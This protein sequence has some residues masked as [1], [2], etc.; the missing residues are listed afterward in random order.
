MELRVLI[1]G[2]WPSDWLEYLR[3]LLDDGITLSTDSGSGDYHVLVSGRPDESLI[4]ASPLLSHLII[5]WAGLPAGTR[6]LM[7][8]HSRISVHNIHHNSG[9][10][11]EL[12]L[13]LILA[14]SRL[15]VPADRALRKGD[16]SWR[17]RQEDCVLI[18]GSRM[19]VL[20]Y[21]SIG[22]KVAAA[23]LALGA[24]VTGIR[25]SGPSAGGEVPVVPRE[26]L[27]SLLPETDILLLSLPLTGET[28]DI[29]DS[30]RLGLMHERSVLVNI[31][32]GGLVD[33]EALF[34]CLSEGSIGAAG[35][36]VWYRYPDSEDT[37]TCTRPSR[38][39]FA[40]LDNVVMTPHM[41]GAFGSLSLE[42]SR[43]RHLASSINALGSGGV[44]P[45]EVD[46]ETGY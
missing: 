35:I 6:A 46:L 11:A 3:S 38:F 28:A 36:D 43:A 26:S 37:R 20:G 16:W 18:E 42:M 5:P 24:S 45:C 41:G 34:R 19:L 8:S 2:E 15:I 10:A 13:G 14:A 30:R 4:E 9:S 12:A 33:E 22:R 7:Q 25:R 1:D 21:G 27:D 31:G 44:M 29:M 17:Y 23:C 39:D 32:R 40:S